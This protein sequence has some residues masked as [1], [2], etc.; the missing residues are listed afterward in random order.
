MD[1]GIGDFFTTP[2]LD[3]HSPLAP[4]LD[5]LEKPGSGMDPLALHGLQRNPIKR[6]YLLKL[7]A[8]RNDPLVKGSAR[9]SGC[10][11]KSTRLSSRPARTVKAVRVNAAVRIAELEG[12][13]HK[14][15]GPDGY[16]VRQIG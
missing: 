1:I 5:A 14:G 7:H 13:D 3:R 8:A 11:D 6:C 12:A 9:N 10:L 16:P 2:A 4:V 15:V